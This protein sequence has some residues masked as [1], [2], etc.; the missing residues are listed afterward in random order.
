MTGQFTAAVIGTLLVAS[1]ALGAGAAAADVDYYNNSSKV[2]QGDTPAEPT[3][4]NIVDLFVSLSPDIIGTGEQD[5]SGSGFQGVLLTG[6]M[7]SG[8][9]AGA[10]IGTGIGPIGGGVVATTLSYGLVD[11]GYAPVWLKPILLFGVGI[12]AF[13]ALRR[14]VR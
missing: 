8:A 5:P 3:L 14:V 12:F 4:D 11:A 7:W 9:L 10:M 1:L 13:I 6:L 2:V